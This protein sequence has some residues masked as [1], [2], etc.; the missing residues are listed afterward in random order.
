MLVLRSSTV[1]GEWVGIDPTNTPN[2]EPTIYTDETSVVEGNTAIIKG[3]TS[4][5]TGQLESQG[6]KYWKVTEETE[7]VEVAI[8][9]NAIIIETNGQLMTANLTGLDYNSTYHYVAL[10]GQSLRTRN[11]RS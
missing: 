6:F 7:G 9:T 2:Y 1:L 8:P 4:I 11:F 5:D 10:P 3:Y